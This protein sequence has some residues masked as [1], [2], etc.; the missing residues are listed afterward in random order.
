MIQSDHTNI[1]YVKHS[2]MMNYEY[3][4]KEHIANDN[5]KKG[6]WYEIINDIINPIN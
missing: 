3:V 4:Y 6:K 5:V 1:Y 2:T